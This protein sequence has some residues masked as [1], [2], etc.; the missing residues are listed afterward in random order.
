MKQD[1]LIKALMTHLNP[2]D[3]IT[4][5]ENGTMFAYYVTLAN[6]IL[7]DNTQNQTQTTRRQTTVRAENPVRQAVDLN[8]GQNRQTTHENAEDTRE[9]VQQ[10]AQ[11]QPARNIPGDRVAVRQL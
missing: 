4:A 5:Q 9:T 10:T 7:G 11:R 8:E 1:A 2:Q 3:V 6:N